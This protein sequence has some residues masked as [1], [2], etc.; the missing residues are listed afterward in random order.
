MVEQPKNH[1]SELQFKKFLTSSITEMRWIK[2]VEM[3]D[4]G[5]HNYTCVF[6]SG[7][8]RQSIGRLSLSLRMQQREASAATVRI[9]HSTGEKLNVKLSSYSKR[10]ETCCDTVIQTEVEQRHQKRTG[11]I[12]QVKEYE[13]KHRS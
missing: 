8:E 11:D 7:R 6:G 10:G 5:S 9:Y 4:S 3:V 2:E 12:S 1:I 13:L